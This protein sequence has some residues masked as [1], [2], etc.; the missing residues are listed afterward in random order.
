MQETNETTIV[1]KGREIPAA[2]VVGGRSATRISP[3]EE[4]D[5]YSLFHG[6]FV[7]PFTAVS[8]DGKEIPKMFGLESVNL[9]A[10]DAAEAETTKLS[11]VFDDIRTAGGQ[12]VDSTGRPVVKTP[13]WKVATMVAIALNKQPFSY[14]D[15]I[16][17]G[18]SPFHGIS[19]HEQ[20][21]EFSFWCIRVPGV[22]AASYDAE[23]PL[24]LKQLYLAPFFYRQEEP[25]TARNPMRALRF[26]SR[27]GAEYVLNEIVRPLLSDPRVQ[28]QIDERYA[29]KL[30]KYK[31]DPNFVALARAKWELASPVRVAFAY[32]V[33]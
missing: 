12:V 4:A 31:T 33:Q 15:G 10:T 18:L 28:K 3:E 32:T 1:V 14:L 16:R 20:G 23:K 6:E 7:G 25:I 30:E 2:T 13:S 11:V 19:K 29:K 22:D 24:I 17:T 9:E 8:D 5:I 21:N 27:K 26:T